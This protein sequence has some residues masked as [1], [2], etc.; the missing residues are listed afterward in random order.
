[1]KEIYLDNAATTKPE[2]SVVCI[3]NDVLT[4]DYGNPSSRHKKGVEAEKYIRN[5][6]EIISDILKVDTK[7]IT[8]TSCATESN[9]MAVFGAVEKRKRYGDHIITTALEHASVREPFLELEKKG[10]QVTF[11]QTDNDGIVDTNALKEALDD[12]TILVSVM[13]VNNETGVIQPLEEIGNIIKTYNKDIIFHVDAVQSFGKMTVRPKKFQADMLSVSA[14]KFHG[15]KGS[16]FLYIKDGT[17]IYPLLYGGG[18]QMKLRSGTENT[19]GIAGLGEAAR[20]AYLEETQDKIKALYKLREK[21]INDLL[22]IDGVIVNGVSSEI[23]APHIV[24]ATFKGIRSEVLLHALEEEDI[25]ISSGSACSSN[26]PGLSFALSALGL[27][28]NAVEST[29]RF[30]FSKFTTS[31][32]LDLCINVLKVKVPFLRQFVRR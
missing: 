4:K 11:L 20:I 27:D 6:A 1:M 17:G 3:M 16:G 12:K 9:N 31:D 14:H 5:A 10:Y 19:P 22:S 32:E 18:Q 25:Y 24:S 7:E 28:K 26:K 8:F 13:H 2:E 21:F 15:P 23:F 30:S 29:V